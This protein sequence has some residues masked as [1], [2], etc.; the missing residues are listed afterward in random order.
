MLAVVVAF[1]AVDAVDEC[2]RLLLSVG[3]LLNEGE[4]GLDGVGRL[5]CERR[6]KGCECEHEGQNECADF[7][8]HE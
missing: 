6:A 1:E 7:L 3:V 4:L 8:S 5:C 2:T